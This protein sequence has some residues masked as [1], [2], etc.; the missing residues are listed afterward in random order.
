MTI[1]PVSAINPRLIN[2]TPKSLTPVQWEALRG[3]VC[4]LVTQAEP[5]NDGATKPVASNLCQLLAAEL[6][7]KDDAKLE[8]LFTGASITR[9]MNRISKEYIED[10]KLGMRKKYTDS[11]RQVMCSRLKH[12]YKVML[13]FP[14]NQK[15]NDQPAAGSSEIEVKLEQIRT[16]ISQAPVAM[17]GMLNNWLEVG[18]GTGQSPTDIGAGE[19]SAIAVTLVGEDLVVETGHVLESVVMISADPPQV[20]EISSTADVESAVAWWRKRYGPWP[21]RI[22][23]HTR[24]KRL[25]MEPRLPSDVLP[26]IGMSREQL[27]EVTVSFKVDL[28]DH[29]D[30]LRGFSKV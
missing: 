24:A 2:Y 22:I 16:R 10:S 9:H 1:P 21:I 29:R 14:A 8:D 5:R 26:E 18:L 30:V 28:S 25:L 4:L 6:D 19:G 23:R 3:P 20:S 27:N 7:G 12:L 17:R 15:V 11:S 13:G